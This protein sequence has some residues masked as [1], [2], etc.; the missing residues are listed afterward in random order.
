MFGLVIVLDWI[1]GIGMFL[2]LIVSVVFLSVF[3]K[4]NWK[5]MFFLVLLLLL[6]WILYSVFGFI[7]K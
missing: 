1:S 7:E 6:M 2:L 5:V 3:L 4:W